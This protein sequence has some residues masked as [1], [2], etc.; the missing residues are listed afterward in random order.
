MKLPSLSSKPY[1]I[2]NYRV[3]LVRDAVAEVEPFMHNGTQ[4]ATAFREVIPQD[5]DKE[6]FAVAFLNIR[7]RVIGFQTVSI[8]CLSSSLVHP[9]EVFKPAIL[10]SAAAIV[11]CH[12]H[13]SGDPEPSYEDVSLTKRLIQAGQLIGIEVLDHV[14]LGTF[15][16]FCSMKERGLV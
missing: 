13:P 16:R 10:A 7:R 2:G 6:I 15:G 8:G 4:A 12:N 9:R 14:V 1:T 3:S 5:S 11:A